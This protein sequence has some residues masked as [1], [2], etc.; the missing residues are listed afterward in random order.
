[1]KWRRTKKL[2][3]SAMTILA[4]ASIFSNPKTVKADTNVWQNSTY[5]TYF[6]RFND[7]GDPRLEYSAVY[8]MNGNG[9][10]YIS[11]GIQ[12]QWVTGPLN[13]DGYSDGKWMYA[14]N[15]ANKGSGNYANMAD[16]SVNAHIHS[17]G[18]TGLHAGGI[19]GT[20]FRDG[21]GWIEAMQLASTEELGKYA[22]INYFAIC[23][24]VS[25]DE[26]RRCSNGNFDFDSWYAGAYVCV[27][28]ANG[29]YRQ[30]FGN[31]T[32]A[33]YEKADF[34][35]FNMGIGGNW[36]GTAGYSLPMYGF[37]ATMV[38]YPCDVYINPNGGVWAGSTNTA[39]IGLY[40]GSNG[41]DTAIRAGDELTFRSDAIP[42][43]DGYT[44]AG[45][46]LSF[47]RTESSA[48]T[49]FQSPNTAID[50]VLVSGNGSAVYKGYDYS[51]VYNYN[52]YR[53]HNQDL[54]AVF[55]DD[56]S[57][58]LE[59]FANYGINEGRRAS[60]NFDYV[61]YKN[62]YEDVRNALGDNTALYYWH[63]MQYGA[64]GG[65][66]GNGQTAVPST[67][68]SLSV[69]NASSIALTAKWIPHYTLT[70]DTNKPT[71]PASCYS[72]VCD[73]TGRKIRYGSKYGSYMSG[74]TEY[75]KSLPT[76]T[77]EGY[78]FDGWYT[79]PT[80]GTRIYDTSIYN[81]NGDSTIYAHW[82]DVTAPSSESG[83]VTIRS[84][85]ENWANYDVLVTSYAKD[86]GSG[87][88]TISDINTEK[89]GIMQT[90]NNVA[91][92]QTY[93]Q[94]TEKAT[95][96]YNESREGIYKYYATAVDYA[97]N[98][99]Q[100]NMRATVK[101]DKTA[102]AA[103]NAGMKYNACYG[104]TSIFVDRINDNGVN[105][106][107]VSLND[108]NVSKLCRVWAE[109]HPGTDPN[110]SEFTTLELMNVPG[111]TTGTNSYELQ[112]S[113][114]SEDGIYGIYPDAAK[115]TVV[116]KA[117]DVAGNVSRQKDNRFST[118]VNYSGDASDPNSPWLYKKT[119][120]NFY[121]H[122]TI[123]RELGDNGDATA[124]IP[125][126]FRM[127]E[128]GTLHIYVAGKVDHIKID[129]PQEFEEG[130]ATQKTLNT[131]TNSDGSPNQNYDADL[132]SRILS[133]E[134][135]I[136]PQPKEQ[137]G[138]NKPIIGSVN[139]YVPYDGSY[140]YDVSAAG[141]MTGGDE[142][143]DFYVPMD[144][145]KNTVHPYTDGQ[146]YTVTVT[147]SKGAAT[148]VSQPQLKVQ[149]NVQYHIQTR[150]RDPNASN[151]EEI[152]WKDVAEGNRLH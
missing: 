17:Y 101:I 3:F 96:F 78:R 127:G 10:D 95:L 118:Y 37:A 114:L 79:A 9:N 75:E 134:F 66:S 2:L 20:Q 86:S 125:N 23:N 116:I 105:T 84:A 43:R 140:G 60:E 99:A 109:V 42:Y 64:F 57:K 38:D 152:F 115:I 51:A 11:Y 50:P 90:I 69:G 29:N 35:H 1:M 151:N 16:I 48:G 145:D 62:N 55:G 97:G 132:V 36:A 113:D 136:V 26:V 68:Y 19:N 33:V 72:P 147:G 44:F 129:F 40:N 111:G 18:W 67:Q 24:P 8:T 119:I 70:F 139:E 77:L 80:G 39:Q 28:A 7:F 108:N 128:M 73:E 91:A 89:N 76:P 27:D 92:T 149:D 59:H 81:V 12:G 98:A 52:Y 122:A 82:T 126:R 102:P 53:S 85:T 135:D 25:P 15:F 123:T 58:Y 141:H 61:Y 133:K 74:T 148:S 93:P 112:T 88:K 143:Y 47:H 106:N 103:A 121:V 6:E 31:S 100:S 30:F 87:I 65:Y 107:G 137:L 71:N 32:G 117:Q 144:M 142:G 110:S 46:E 120:D 124:N 104:V 34:E 13:S 138:Y 22:Y 130:L 94:A 14:L 63:Y 45:W 131:I 150:L 146:V 4:G 21:T 56:Q 5:N 54:Q 49:N 41:I 83:S